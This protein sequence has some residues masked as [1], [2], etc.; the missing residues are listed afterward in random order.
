MSD[1]TSDL[2]S[3][4]KTKQSLADLLQRLLS[5]TRIDGE[6]QGESE[7][8]RAL[9][10]KLAEENFAIAVVGQ[11]N[12]GKSTLLNAFLGRAVL[13]TGVLPVTSVI[14]SIT[15]GATERLIIKRKG[16]HLPAVVP[17]EK[18]GDYVTEAGNPGNR[19]QIEEAIVETALPLA[20]RG[21]SFV[22][23]P[24]IASAQAA[25]TVTT[26]GFLPK[27]DA[28]IFVTSVESPMTGPELDLLRETLKFAQKLFVV[29][30]KF[31][32]VEGSNPDEP[33]RLTAWVK[34]QVRRISGEEPNIYP[35][36]SL[37]ALQR[38]RAAGADG[39][40][41]GLRALM[42]DLEQF[43]AEKGQQVFLSSVYIKAIRLAS[44][45]ETRQR[46]SARIV[47]MRKEGSQRALEALAGRFESAEREVEV[48]LTDLR[49]RLF[50]HVAAVEAS[51]VSMT[52][53]WHSFLAGIT[54]DFD[55]QFATLPIA[56][57]SHEVWQDR[58][59]AELAEEQT[60]WLAETL[61]KMRPDLFVEVRLAIER[62]AEAL[63]SMD[64]EAA[65]ILVP[66]G[67]AMSSVDNEDSDLP[68]FTVLRVSPVTMTIR[69]SLAS[70]FGPPALRRRL[71]RR[72]LRKK[73]D[74]VI[75]AS[76]ERVIASCRGTL[77]VVADTIARDTR[78]GIRRRRQALSEPL[79]NTSSSSVLGSESLV[80]D[81]MRRL[82]SL[83][84]S[85][86]SGRAAGQSASTEDG[87][88]QLLAWTE[89]HSAAASSY[90]DAKHA[91]CVVCAAETNAQFALFAEWQYLLARDG[92]FREAFVREGGFCPLHTWQFEQIASPQTLSYGFAP[93]LE[94]IVTKLD[95]AASLSLSEIAAPLEALIRSDRTCTVCAFLRR[96]EEKAVQGF[97]ADLAMPRRKQSLETSFG[98]CLPHFVT[99]VRCTNDESRRKLLFSHQIGRL[100]ETVDNMRSYAVKRESLRRELVRSGEENAWNA[101]L[102]RI[103]GERNLTMSV[104]LD[105]LL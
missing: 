6:D 19:E 26:Y 13:P 21:V 75:G 39:D 55:R 94:S 49:N 63:A 40:T 69:P 46:L 30:N 37:R 29:I 23:T 65:G 76:R 2:R 78:R 81:I 67:N 10:A 77:S 99:A 102:R 22:D 53:V 62:I 38:G 85:I 98:L 12:R 97:L 34:E 48:A 100:E 41:S 103:V 43:L 3:Y 31:D 61:R 47:Q 66:D 88:P 20:R 17:L 90:H 11:F 56:Q 15:Y 92:R 80:A 8:C 58:L 14:T 86:L 64:R 52:P 9:L 59:L 96:E 57:L 93:L 91:R 18:I 82:E 74:A 105:R 72:S 27:V 83:K 28:A 101:A 42:H 71:I 89:T 16:A 95:H 87:L 35:V 7:R 73:F 54:A 60:T 1:P 25:N 84:S 4:T 70:D 50:S 32:L 36:S 79:E 51:M 68:D 33:K 44:E 24:G 5:A 104:Q 45:V